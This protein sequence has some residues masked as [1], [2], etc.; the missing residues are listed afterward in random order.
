MKET[1]EECIEKNDQMDSL[2][3]II[4]S[5]GTFRNQATQEQV[6]SAL[7]TFKTPQKRY[8]FLSGCLASNLTVGTRKD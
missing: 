6:S 7:V 5:A 3:D 4:K 8:R 2:Y 1:G